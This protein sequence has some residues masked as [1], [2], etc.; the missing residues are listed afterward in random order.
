MGLRNLKTKYKSS[1]VGL[2]KFILET[3]PWALWFCSPRETWEAIGEQFRDVN[4][5]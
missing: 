2:K 4:G 3:S 1:E 5:S